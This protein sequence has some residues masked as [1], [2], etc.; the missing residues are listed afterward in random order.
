MKAMTLLLVIA[1]FVSC[2]GDKKSTPAGTATTNQPAQQR[3]RTNPTTI[4]N[5][6]SG[7]YVFAS[8][9]CEGT[10]AEVIDELNNYIKRGLKKKEEAAVH[11][12]TTLRTQN[13]E[14]SESH[15]LFTFQ[16]NRKRAK[17]VILRM[18]T[19]NPALTE[20]SYMGI[21]K[22][23]KINKD[24][25]LTK[26]NFDIVHSPNNET[27]AVRLRFPENKMKYTMPLLNITGTVTS[28]HECSRL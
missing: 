13:G 24:T 3:T 11:C 26:E 20:T 22:K 15:S 27:T 23:I 5:T 8:G 28:S 18:R 19:L 17:R 6:Q 2:G 10:K 1:S 12:V 7:D 21:D 25:S 4:N 16:R 9:G 14:C